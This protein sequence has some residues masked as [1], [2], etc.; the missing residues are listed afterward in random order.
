MNQQC[1][2]TI[3]GAIVL[4]ALVSLFCIYSF[5]IY[6]GVLGAFPNWNPPPPFVAYS[7]M[8]LG[9]GGLIA[10]V[11]LWQQKR[12]AWWL[13]TAVA[14]VFL[15]LAGPG[16]VMDQRAMGQAISLVLTILLGLLLALLALPATRKALA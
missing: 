1:P 5:G 6:V 12:W 10:M 14:A 8:A 16:I 3:T 7:A 15:L 13:A 11:G 4:L 9:I 2:I